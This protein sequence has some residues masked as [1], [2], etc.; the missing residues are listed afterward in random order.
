VLR[1]AFSLILVANVFAQV[2][3]FKFDDF[4]LLV[5]CH[6]SLQVGCSSF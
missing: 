4:L 1:N 2:L 5:M 3:Y 6:A